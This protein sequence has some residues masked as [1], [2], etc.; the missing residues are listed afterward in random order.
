MIVDSISRFIEEFNLPTPLSILNAAFLHPS[1]KLEDPTS[2]T[3]EVLETVGDTV[4]DLMVIDKLLS[5]N[6]Y[7]DPA[8]LTLERAVLVNNRVLAE[9]AK[10]L[11]IPPLI[12]RSENYDLQ[13]KDLADVLEAIFGIIYMNN[14]L[15]ECRKL[16]ETLWADWFS[17]AQQFREQVINESNPVGKLQEMT[18][19]RRLP[20]PKY[21]VINKRGPEH[22]PEFEMRLNVDLRDQQ[23]EVTVVSSSIRKAKIKAATKMLE[24]IHSKRK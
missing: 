13:F 19:S 24:K 3:Y 17:M 1:V 7:P 20:L 6:Y 21:E 18:Q 16:F 12:K 9:V 14:G 11:G 22:S 4:L 5:L 15:D 2:E 8:Y 23:Y 10:S